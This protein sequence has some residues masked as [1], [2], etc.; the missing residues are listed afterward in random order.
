MK[1]IAKIIFLLLYCITQ[2]FG[3]PP[4]CLDTAYIINANH[5]YNPQYQANYKPCS[6]NLKLGNNI[7]KRYSSN[8]DERAKIF[9]AKNSI[10]IDSLNIT[11]PTAN[12]YVDI[13]AK[14]IIFK[15]NLEL[16][17]TGSYTPLGNYEGD[18]MN[19]SNIPCVDAVVI[20]QDD[21]IKVFTHKISKIGFRLGKPGFENCSRFYSLTGPLNTY[22]GAH[23]EF[24]AVPLDTNNNILTG[25][26]RFPVYD[27]LGNENYTSHK[28]KWFIKYFGKSNFVSYPNRE[29]SISICNNYA[30]FKVI[31][32]I[33]VPTLG[34][35]QPNSGAWCK[36]M[37]N[38]AEVYYEIPALGNRPA[39]KSL[40]LK[41]NMIGPCGGTEDREVLCSSLSCNQSAFFQEQN[42]IFPNMANLRLSEE[43]DNKESKNIE[44]DQKKIKKL[45]NTITIY[46]NPAYDSFNISCNADTK[47]LSSK[48]LNISGQVINQG[49]DYF[50][51]SNLASGLYIVEIHTNDH[52][53]RKTVSKY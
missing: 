26:G 45:T 22:Y 38:G 40:I 52:I 1:S 32:T 23:F 29:N 20:Q 30:S 36:E 35:S 53:Y 46:P 31:N 16:Q 17:A 49:L 2:T 47:I 18:D 41:V 13:N 39:I 4:S 14:E 28:G 24:F 8:L 11:R 48:L 25:D 42:K 10:I 43:T 44:L 50:D 5:Y 15:S 21:D 7:L 37:L 51:I 12:T 19:F 9:N 3:T 33:G 6:C 34:D 27:S